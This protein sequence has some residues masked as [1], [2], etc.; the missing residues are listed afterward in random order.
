[1]FTR[2]TV[3][4]SILAMLWTGLYNPAYEE[5][6][7]TC[8][9][10]PNQG[11]KTSLTG[12]PLY[13][14]LNQ[15]PLTLVIRPEIPTELRTRIVMAANVWNLVVG[16][17]IFEIGPDRLTE[18][19]SRNTIVITGPLSESF[20]DHTLGLTSLGANVMSGVIQH[21]QME[22]LTN[23]SGPKAFQIALHEL[24]HALGLAHDHEDPLSV[25]YPYYL[26]DKAILRENDI[27]YVKSTVDLECYRAE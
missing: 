14:A 18:L 27:Q 21:A 22:L 6:A 25:M 4:L 17:T 16:Y 2:T 13:W 26:T 9:F 3:L 12:L 20:G 24:G 11:L 19:S 15:Y 7:S 8:N 10:D 23:L 1:M 5:A